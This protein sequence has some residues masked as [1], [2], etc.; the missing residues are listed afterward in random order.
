MLSLSVHTRF[1][2]DCYS[3]LS[4]GNAK[5]AD[6]QQFIQLQYAFS[7]S[8]VMLRALVCAFCLMRPAQ[9]MALQLRQ[10]AHCVYSC[11]I[12]YPLQDANQAQ[13][14]QMN[15]NCAVCWSSMTVATDEDQSVVSSTSA[16]DLP[17][18]SPEEEEEQSQD[19]HQGVPHGFM[20]FPFNVQA[21]TAADSLAAAEEEEDEAAM[22]QHPCKALP[23]GHAFHDTCIAKW[24]S[25]CHV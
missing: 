12:C 10:S 20:E 14:E 2:G 3:I 7:H 13:I 16:V 1:L 23:C 18:Q 15:G 11:K 5:H 19:V 8:A 4:G 22:E 9:H 21:A 25:Q 6:R 24:L 17:M